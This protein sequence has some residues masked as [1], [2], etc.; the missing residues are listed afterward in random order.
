MYGSNISLAVFNIPLKYIPVVKSVGGIYKLKNPLPVFSVIDNLF[1]N[2][3][4][5]IRRYT[6]LYVIPLNVNKS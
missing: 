5:G 2:V 6:L 3:K 4:E 1:F